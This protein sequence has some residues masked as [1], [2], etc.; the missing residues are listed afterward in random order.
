LGWRG[1]PP[2]PDGENAP[3]LVNGSVKEYLIPLAKDIKSCHIN[4]LCNPAYP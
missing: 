3:D 2:G 1:K 4:E